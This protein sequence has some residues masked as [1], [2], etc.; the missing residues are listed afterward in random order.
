M[1][2]SSFARCSHLTAAIASLLAASA[3]QS[4]NQTW[5]G[6]STANGNWAT[7]AN[8]VGDSAAPGATTGSANTD[9]ALFNAA[10][11]NNWGSN[12]TGYKIVTTAGLNL[13]NIT[14]DTA[15]GNYYIGGTNV[16]VKLTSG[17]TIG[18]LSGITGTNVT[19]TINARLAIYG[20]DGTYTFANNSATGYGAGQG[21]L[22][23]AGGITGAAAG[24][25]VLTLSGSNGN[26]NTISG[27]IDNGSAD[28]FNV[29]K[30]GTGT[31][32]LTGA[33]TFSGQLAVA[34]GVLQ[35]TSVNWSDQEGALGFSTNAVILGDA[36]KTGTLDYTGTGYCLSDKL[37]TLASSGSGGIMVS[38]LTAALELTGVINGDGS[39]IKSGGGMLSLS[40]ENTYT[41]TTTLSGGTLAAGYAENAGTSGPFGTNTSAGSII[42]DGGALQYSTANQYDYSARLTTIG[43][44]DYRIDTNSQAVSFATGLLVSGTSGLVKSG[45]GTL[46]LNAASTYTGLTTIQGGTLQL[47]VN[48]AI[49]SGNAVTINDATADQTATLDLNGYALTIGGNG[50]TL[51]GYNASN[52]AQVTGTGAG[53]V[54]TLSGGSTALTYSAANNPLGA[55]ISATTVDLNNATQTFTVGNSSSAAHDLSVSSVMQN[56]SLIKDEAGTMTLTGTNAYTGQT[57]ISGGVLQLGNDGET[58]SLNSS[59]AVVNN[60]TLT[61]K[62]SNALTQSNTISGTG[63]VIQAGSGTTTLSG[64][65]TYTGTTS[66]QAGVLSIN[67]IK[68]VSAGSSALGAPT[69]AANGTIA[70]GS[71]TT[72]AQLTYTGGAQV[73][74]RVINLVGTSGGATLDQASAEAAIL[75]FISDLKADGIG[76]KTLTLMGSSAGTGEISGAIVNNATENST[77]LAAAFN[78]G[79]NTITLA[80]V[81]GLAIGAAISGAGINSGTTVTGINPTTKIVTLSNNTNSSGTANQAIAVSGV[82]NL[83][84]LT[85]E[86]T[87]TWTL[88]GTNTYTGQTTISGGTLQLGNGGTSGKLSPSSPIVDNATLT[89]KRSDT[90][91]QGTDFNSVISGS[92]GVIQAGSGITILNGVNTYHGGTTVSAGT[93]VVNNSTGS[94]TGSGAVLVEVGA[95][96]KGSGILAGATTIKGTHAPGNSPGTQSFES[97]LLYNAESIFEWDLASNKD[98]LSGNGGTT[99]VRGTDF[100]AVNV[101]GNLGIAA[102]AIFKIVLGVNFSPEDAFW[103]QREVWAVFDVTGTKTSNFDTFQVFDPSNLTTPLNVSAAGHFSFA[104]NTDSLGAD[105]GNLIWS[106]VPEPT[107]ALAGLLLGASLL[108]RRR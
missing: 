22:N 98:S 13:K 74:D 51:G 4:A 27:I 62:R 84:A 14:F 70:I 95:I 53:S 2:L 103:K 78:S 58:G 39:L 76:S 56:G 12:P 6:G 83:T 61:F 90:L 50:L 7:V 19:E 11:A 42:F 65:N 97:D 75:K 46:N 91:T 60:A 24:N 32:A 31:W 108:R 105:S 64:T 59:S 15:A 35:V 87:S 88:S 34:E 101:G 49:K 63:N 8:W 18:I 3:A 38:S 28:T 44:K 17:G 9:T 72:G 80:S 68:S 85:K 33:N 77:S 40:Q 5:D 66:I 21:T 67:N 102:A 37:F 45:S 30:S 41:G 93:L 92:G 107:S 1:K 81:D 96:L 16:T 99:A 48:D 100:D 73:T 43:N 36:G 25:T 82:R 29:T 106:A 86:G 52:T 94:G 54:L 79:V 23:F 104:Y 57:T 71:T 55:V 69:T 89:F 47:G 10:I 20:T 26:A